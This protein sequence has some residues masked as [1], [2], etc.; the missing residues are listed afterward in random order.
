M[1]KDE[2]RDIMKKAREE[3]SMEKVQELSKSMFAHF[4][5]LEFYHQTDTI[6]SYVSYQKEV[7][8][9]EWIKAL[10]SKENK[11]NKQLYVPRVRNKDMDFFHLTT[12][13][14]LESGIF[15][16]LEPKL[17]KNS[18]KYE[19]KQTHRPPVMILPGLAFDL[20]GN[21]VGY[22]G[23]YYDRYLSHFP[24]DYFIKIV[25][26]FDFQIVDCLLCEDYDAKIDYII[27]PTRDYC[28]SKLC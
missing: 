25:F 5:G 2:A 26:A 15:G 13:D 21:R 11:D 10:L 1:I 18:H 24:K 8:T 12:Y 20:S 3:M 7:E 9:R 22:G 4:M 27:T 6:L 19:K 17:K 14:Q 16:I 23:G 28:I